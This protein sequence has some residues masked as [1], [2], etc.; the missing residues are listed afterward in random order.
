MNFVNYWGEG[1]NGGKED[2][3][4]RFEKVL[5]EPEELTKDEKIKILENI[6]NN[7][8]DYKLIYGYVQLLIF[9]LTDN[10]QKD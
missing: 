1:F 2:F 4:Q 5:K 8:D 7:I 9:Y 10:Y 6:K 3:L